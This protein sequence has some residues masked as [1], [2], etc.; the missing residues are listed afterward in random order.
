MS[1][2]PSRTPGADSRN[3]TAIGKAVKIV[4]EIISKEDLQIDGDV[5]GAIAAQ[6]R[7]ITIGSSGRIQASILARD[8]FIVG[9][10]QGNLVASGKVELREDSR[11]IGDITSPRIVLD[12]GAEV[13]GKIDTVGA[14]MP[15]PRSVV[16]A[17]TQPVASSEV[18]AGS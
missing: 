8:I 14:R 3:T 17:S 10:V 7:K 5:E 16:V 4:G 15:E 1:P 13:K 2:I 11:L 18:A 6:D 12:D 9:Q